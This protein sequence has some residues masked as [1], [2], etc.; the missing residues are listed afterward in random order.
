MTRY[1]ARV[2]ENHSDIVA[3]FRKYP[4]IKVNDCSAYGGGF[5]DL[6]V[7]IFDAI[8][9][10]EVKD[11]NKPP[12]RRTLTPSQETF[13]AIFPVTIVESIEDVTRFVQQQIDKRKEQ[14]ES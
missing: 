5:P 7:L 4:F 9:L 2:D 12:S 10:V 3:E 11:G 6:L 14:L 13:H 1:A 8:H